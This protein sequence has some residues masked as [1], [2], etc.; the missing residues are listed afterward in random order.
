MSRRVC[1]ACGKTKELKDG[2]TCANGH[3]V[4]SN[5][6]YI[7]GFLFDSKRTQCPLCKKPLR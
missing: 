7:K 4:C 6:K 5:C 1:D 3:F 2:V